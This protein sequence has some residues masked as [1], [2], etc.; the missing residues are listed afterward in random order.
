MIFSLKMYLPS[1]T[2]TYV[3]NTCPG[4]VNVT[5]TFSTA[6]TLSVRISP[7]STLSLVSHTCALSVI[8]IVVV[9]KSLFRSLQLICPLQLSSVPP[10]ATQIF[11]LNSTPNAGTLSHVYVKLG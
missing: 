3:G 7:V 5:A 1:L 9:Q 2:V 8:T 10:S 11:T 6:W 4:L